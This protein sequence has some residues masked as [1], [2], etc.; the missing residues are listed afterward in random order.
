MFDGR[1][2][3]EEEAHSTV[4]SHPGHAHPAAGDRSL[5]THHRSLQVDQ[6]QVRTRQMT[7]SNL[8]YKWIAN[9]SQTTATHFDICR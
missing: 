8:W 7:I 9:I 1:G 2:S 4:G 5:Q 3:H 6:A